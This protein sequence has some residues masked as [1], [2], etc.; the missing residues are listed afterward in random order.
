MSFYWKPFLEMNPDSLGWGDFRTVENQIDGQYEAEGGFKSSSSGGFG[1]NKS[2]GK[3]Q[4]VLNDDF[5]VKV[6]PDARIWKG[7]KKTA[8][9]LDHE[10]IHYQFAYVLARAM[11]NAMDALRKSKTSEFTHVVATM[12]RV[13][14]VERAAALHKKY[15][16]ETD[17]GM[18]D[19]PQKRWKAALATCVADDTATTLMGLPL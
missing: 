7:A 10:D 13:H 8:A 3:Y 15:D 4:M 6:W 16:K 5:R 12:S 17:H 11:L 19:A 1:Y 18:N 14:M 2:G 9:L